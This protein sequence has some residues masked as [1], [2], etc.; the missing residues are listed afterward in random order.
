M[1]QGLWWAGTP[2][3]DPTPAP[4]GGFDWSSVHPD[5]TFLPKAGLFIQMMDALQWLGIV[6]AFC[7]F[8]GGL[9]AF[10]VGPVFGAHIVS[11]RGKSMT[12]RASLV[13]ILVGS[14][15]TIVSWLLSR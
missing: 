5:P 4:T 11:D 3:A 10:A 15:V 1:R 9:I 6:A 12:W 8:I 2:V 13:A 7:G 14:A